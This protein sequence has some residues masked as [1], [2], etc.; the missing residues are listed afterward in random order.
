M[1]FLV[2]QILA[3]LCVAAVVGGVSGW[4]LRDL[5][6]RVFEGKTRQIS[7]DAVIRLPQVEASLRERDE[8]LVDFKQQIERLEARLNTAPTAP[9]EQPITSGR[10]SSGIDKIDPQREVVAGDLLAADADQLIAKLSREIVRLKTQHARELQA[11]Q[12][13]LAAQMPQG[14]L[15][16]AEILKLQMRLGQAEQ[17]LALVQTDLMNEREKIAQMIGERELQHRSLQ[18]LQ[19]QLHE[20]RVRPAASA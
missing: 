14:P 5:R 4:L 15:E 11:C 9:A 3:Y 8:R 13:E 6:S 12:M 7:E 19:Q 20:E 16:S 2:G 10:A 18:L 1:M 17:S